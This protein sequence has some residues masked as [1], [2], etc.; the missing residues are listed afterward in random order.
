MT[1][2]RPRRM[3]VVASIDPDLYDALKQLAEDN[4][5]VVDQQVSYLLKVALRPP[6]VASATPAEPAA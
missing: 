5:R 2:S 4:E 6:P 1:E 3:R